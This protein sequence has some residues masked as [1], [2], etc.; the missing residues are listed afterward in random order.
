[1]P[2][3]YFK[4]K[5][6]AQLDQCQSS[7]TQATSLGSNSTI[8]LPVTSSPCT[9]ASAAETES[10]VAAAAKCPGVPSVDPGVNEKNVGAIT[11]PILEELAAC[12]TEMLV[13]IGHLTSECTLIRHDLDKTWGRFTKAEDRISEVEDAAHTHGSQLSEL[14]YLVRSL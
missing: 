9:K 4:Q 14:Q 2:T 6:K 8:L 7:Y 1:M 11:K 5:G 13:H 10:E 3:S 12:K